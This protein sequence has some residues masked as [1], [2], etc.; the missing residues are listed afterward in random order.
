M[1]CVILN[2]NTAPAVEIVI[3][4]WNVV[5]CSI[6]SDCNALLHKLTLFLCSQFNIHE[7]IH[8]NKLCTCKFTWIFSCGDYWVTLCAFNVLSSVVEWI[9]YCKCIFIILRVKLLCNV[10]RNLLKATKWDLLID[11]STNVCMFS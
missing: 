10:N 4:K 3:I 7:Q 5:C 11:V 8:R 1:R 9:Y 2:Q 6:N